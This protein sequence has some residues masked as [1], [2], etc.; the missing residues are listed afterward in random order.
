M[1]YNN[2]IPIIASIPVHWAIEDSDDMRG[3][4][5]YE[6]S[7]QITKCSNSEKLANAKCVLFLSDWFVF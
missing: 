7:E 2:I 4:F 6:Y 5:Y 3:K 1:I